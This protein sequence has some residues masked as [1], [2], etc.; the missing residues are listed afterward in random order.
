MPDLDPRLH[1]V[2]ATAI[3]VKDSL[4]AARGKGLYLIAKRSE[5][6]KAFPG[7]WTVPGGKLVTREYR[8]LA[9]SVAGY[10]GW[11]GLLDWLVRKEVREEVG[12][13]IGNVSY[14]TDVVFFRPDGYPVVT[15]SFWA[16]WAS[17]EVVL[18]K[19]LTEH[20]WVSL[21]EAG[22]YDLIEGILGEIRMVD[23]H[24]RTPQR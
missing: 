19:D 2:V 10:E 15:L 21:E 24:L 14:V 8:G 4:D 17:G 7:K 23:E 20:A 1:F 11:Y 13:E 22:S 12:L 6:E 5:R 9:K 3:I 18:G 16:P